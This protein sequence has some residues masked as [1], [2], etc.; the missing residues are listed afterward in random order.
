MTRDDRPASAEGR[1]RFRNVLSRTILLLDEMLDRQQLLTLADAF[2]SI[3]WDFPDVAWQ[4][5]LVVDREPPGLRLEPR[6]EGE[7]GL[8]VV[9]DS[10]VLYAAA[11]GETAPMKPS[12]AIA[13]FKKN[14]L[15]GQQTENDGF[16]ATLPFVCP[17]G[18]LFLNFVSKAPVK[19]SIKLWGYGSEYEGFT[20]EDCVAVT[21]DRVRGEIVWKT[22]ASLDELKG[23]YIRIK[24]SGR[25]AVAY[26]AAFEGR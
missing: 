11:A 16:F 5:W 9:M 21:G 23:K 2:T 25:N 13:T 17:G 6:A 19:V 18:K 3:C 14:R 26:S 7:S 8:V 10:T 22:K 15:V 12:L 20:L 1:D 4:A 24:V